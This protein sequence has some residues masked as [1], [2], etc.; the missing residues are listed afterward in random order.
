MHTMNH[1]NKDF[2]K[3]IFPITYFQDNIDN[4]NKIKDIIVPKIKEDYNKLSIPEG[5]ITNKVNTSFSSKKS[6]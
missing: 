1:I 6:K 3:R 4:N 2:Q 5:W